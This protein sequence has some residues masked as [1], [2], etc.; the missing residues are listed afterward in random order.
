IDARSGRRL[1]ARAG[2]GGDHARGSDGGGRRAGEDDAL[3]GR[4]GRRLRG[5]EALPDPRALAGSREPYR[6]VPE[7]HDAWR[8][9]SELAA[10]D[11]PRDPVGSGREPGA[12]GGAMRPARVYLDYNA[13]AP[14]REEA[15]RAMADAFA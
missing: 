14:L 8:R 5:G 7:R 3:L 13:T 9:D 4:G 12:G 15:G 1:Q 11:D 6:V 10:R 2:R